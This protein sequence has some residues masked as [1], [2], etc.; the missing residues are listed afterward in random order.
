MIHINGILTSIS[1]VI[2]EFVC[3]DGRGWGQILYGEGKELLSPCSCLL[4]SK[5]WHCDD[6]MPSEDW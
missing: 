4:R 5:P 1:A 2:E 3:V 6:Y